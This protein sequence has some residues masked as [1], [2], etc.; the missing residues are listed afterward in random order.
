MVSGPLS[1]STSIALLRTSRGL[2]TVRFVSV[3]TLELRW[4]VK[5]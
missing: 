1:R 3:I 4:L 2:V 5:K